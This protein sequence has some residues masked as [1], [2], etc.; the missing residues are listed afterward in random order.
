LNVKQ[1]LIPHPFPAIDMGVDAASIDNPI[2][3]DIVVLKR[4]GA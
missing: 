2:G 1:D 3:E 4:R